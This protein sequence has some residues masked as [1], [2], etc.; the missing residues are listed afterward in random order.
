MVNIF[1]GKI[2]YFIINIVPQIFGISGSGNCCKVSGLYTEN[3]DIIA[4]ITRISPLW[5]IYPRFPSAMPIS[6]IFAI[7]RGINTSIST[8]NVTRRGA[9]M[10]C[11]CIPGRIVKVSYSFFYIPPYVL[12][13]YRASGRALFYRSEHQLRKYLS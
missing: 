13:R 5:I 2:L 9:M 11:F 10:D 3:R 7:S 1:K 12:I 4:I 6:I 8:S